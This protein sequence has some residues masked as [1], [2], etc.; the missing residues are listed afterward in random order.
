MSARMLTKYLLQNNCMR[1][2]TIS[3]YV[4]RHRN[5]RKVQIAYDLGDIRKV[6]DISNISQLRE[7]VISRIQIIGVGRPR[8]DSR[9]FLGE[10][11]PIFQHGVQLFLVNL[12]A[13]IVWN[14]W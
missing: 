3:N 4:S 8:R 11:R 10:G 1:D 12:N 2:R 7:D 13:D 5:S 6:Y 14:V 9:Q